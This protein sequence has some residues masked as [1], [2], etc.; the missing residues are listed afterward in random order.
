MLE[1][2]LMVQAAP[3]LSE[4]ECVVESDPH[5]IDLPDH[6]EFVVRL[7]SVQPVPDLANMLTSR[8]GQNLTV[9]ARREFLPDGVRAGASVRL[10]LEVT[11]P[12]SPVFVR[13]A[14]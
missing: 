5:P 10:F 1:P 2:A 7:V 13:P 6:V 14:P 8:V 4:A 11:G 12:V 3:N 9:R